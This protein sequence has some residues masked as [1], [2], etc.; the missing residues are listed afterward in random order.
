M[1]RPEAKREGTTAFFLKFIPCF[2]F[3]TSVFF[4]EIIRPKDQAVQYTGKMYGHI[5]NYNPYLVV[6]LVFHHL[7]N[8]STSI[9]SRSI[10][11]QGGTKASEIL[12]K[13]GRLTKGI[14]K[15]GSIAIARKERKEAKGKF[16]RSDD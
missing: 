16:V 7:L 2:I 14:H 5:K 10:Y 1:L 4:N 11:C 8:I 3:C 12:K 6:L 13:Q 9:S 15:T